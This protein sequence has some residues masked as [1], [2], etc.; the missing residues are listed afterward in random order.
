MVSKV[1]RITEISLGSEAEASKLARALAPFL[2]LLQPGEARPVIDKVCIWFESCRS[3]IEAA[4]H[5][6]VHF[7]APEEPVH[8]TLF[9]S[10]CL[11]ELRA[12]A[13]DF[14]FDPKR[15]NP[16]RIFGQ[17][18]VQEK[19]EGLVRVV[20]LSLY[21]FILVRAI[22]EQSLRGR[23]EFLATGDP[24]KLRCYRQDL[25]RAFEDMGCVF[26]VQKIGEKVIGEIR[27]YMRFM[28]REL[29]RMGLPKLLKGD[30]RKGY[31]PDTHPD[32][33]RTTQAPAFAFT[34]LGKEVRSPFAESAEPRRIAKQP[35]RDIRG[36]DAR[37]GRTTDKK[38]RERE[39][40]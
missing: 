6:Q 27:D 21:R 28:N 1:H 17:L 2:P 19:K 33:I 3:G 23:D 26:Q 18:L 20:N 10:S 36:N 24:R 13:F 16:N 12:L 29:A 8:H 31:W 39:K 25:E 11:V 34:A 35:E 40:F 37:Y 38:P 14:P 22:M 15:F 4:I 7:C 5:R 30:L 32:N 9:G